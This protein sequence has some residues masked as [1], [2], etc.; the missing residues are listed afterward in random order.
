MWLFW[1][2]LRFYRVAGWRGW[3]FGLELCLDHQRHS[4]WPCEIG[5]ICPFVFFFGGGGPIWLTTGAPGQWNDWRKF[6]VVPRS[7]P[8]RPLVL[9]FL[10]RGGNRRAFRPP[11]EGGGTFPLEP[12]PGH[13][14]CRFSPSFYSHFSSMLAS[15]QKR[16]ISAK[17][18]FLA[19]RSRRTSS[20]KLRWGPPNPGKKMYF[21]RTCRADDHGLIQGKVLC[22]SWPNT[23]H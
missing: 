12:S 6:C 1:R 2:L 5:T 14:R 20:Q 15:L 16:S 11:G 13:I 18:K 4:V 23:L 8:L 3:L 9:F 22:I 10:Y 21:G 17:R 7:H 19:G